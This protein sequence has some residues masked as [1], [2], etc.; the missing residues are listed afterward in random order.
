MRHVVGVG[1]GAE[2][3][4]NQEVPINN[5]MKVL[6]ASVYVCHI[7]NEKLQKTR[8]HGLTQWPNFLKI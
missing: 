3:G 2:G 4:H 8:P 6:L 5:F 7:S 1:A